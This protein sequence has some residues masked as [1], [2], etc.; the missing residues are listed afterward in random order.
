MPHRTMIRQFSAYFGAWMAGTDFYNR[1]TEILR[2]H[3]ERAHPVRL[4]DLPG[5]QPLLGNSTRTCSS[6]KVPTTYR[7]P[8]SRFALMSG[9]GDG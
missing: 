7:P 6:P 8:S 2:V 4:A 9:D 3:P 1:L 5:R